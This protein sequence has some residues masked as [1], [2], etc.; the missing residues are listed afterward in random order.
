LRASIKVGTRNVVNYASAGQSQKKFWWKFEM[1]LT[2]KSFIRLKYSGE[3]LIE[4][5]SS[6][7][8]PKYLSGQLKSKKIYELHAVKRMIR[9]IGEI[10]SLAYSQ[11]LN[12]CVHQ[13]SYHFFEFGG[14]KSMTSSGPLL[15]SI[16]GYAG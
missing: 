12:V 14:L 7:F 6:W 8:P 10:S 16:S 5:R 2:C 1:V 9:G 4:L 13:I 11:T 15:L 3:R